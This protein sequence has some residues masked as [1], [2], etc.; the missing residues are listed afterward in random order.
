[1]H[2]NCPQQLRV[3]TGHGEMNAFENVG[4][5]DS[6]ADHVDHIRLRQYRADAADYL[7]IAG[8]A[9]QR[10]YVL[11]GDAEVARDIFQELARAGS[12]LA[13][14]AIAEYATALINAHGARVQGPDVKHGADFRHKEDRATGMG[15]H[16]VKVPAAKLHQLALT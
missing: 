14:H 2:I 10:S 13:G 6:P 5:G 11:Q 16:A 4:R 8:A 12:A 1:M 7:W 9:R 3:A 15:G